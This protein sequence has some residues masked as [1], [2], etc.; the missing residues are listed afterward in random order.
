MDVLMNIVT[1]IVALLVTLSFSS[2]SA[3]SKGLPLSYIIQ[4]SGLLQV[5]V[6]TGTETQAK[7]TSVELLRE[8]ISII[9]LDEATASMDS[10]TDTLVQSTIKDAFKDCT[11]LT[12]AHRLNTVLN[13]DR[14]L[15]M[16]NGKVVEF[17]KPEVLAEKLDSAF[18]ML[19]AAE[20]KV[21]L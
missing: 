16:E 3:S 21:R 7:F 20:Q 1:F 19:L 2:I 8:Y 6:R 12:I 13:C 4:L 9:L 10:K 15:V 11:V 18:A 5:C 14:V 17:D